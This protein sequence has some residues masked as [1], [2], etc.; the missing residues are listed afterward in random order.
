MTERTIQLAEEPMP[1]ITDGE[2][3]DIPES[4]VPPVQFS[5]PSANLNEARPVLGTATFRIPKAILDIYRKTGMTMNQPLEA[6][7]VRYEQD[8]PDATP[9]DFQM[10]FQDV[11]ELSLPFTEMHERL[12]R[13][14]AF[15]TNT[16]VIEDTKC[17]MR[18]LVPKGNDVVRL[19]QSN[20][21]TGQDIE[22]TFFNTGIVVNIRPPLD[23]EL[24]DLE[25]K[26]SVDRSNVGMATYGA[27]LTTDMGVHLGHLLDFALSLVTWTNL[28]HEGDMSAALRLHL[29]GRESI[30]VL[31]CGVLAS[32][33][34]TGFPWT[35]Q[36]H[37]GDCVAEEII[38]VFFARAQWTDMS[39]FTDEHRTVLHRNRKVLPEDTCIDYIAKLPNSTDVVE[40]NGTVFYLGLPSV[41]DYAYSTR[42]WLYTIEEENAA[43]LAKIDSPI[44]RQAFLDA[45]IGSRVLLEHSHYIRSIEV[46]NGKSTVTTVERADIEAILISGSMDLELVAKLTN[47]IANFE[48]SSRTTF[49]GHA[50]RPCPTCGK[51]IHNAEGP[52]SSIVPLPADRI[53]FTHTQLKIQILRGLR[54]RT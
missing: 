32:M 40:H 7:A 2:D 24:V 27:S 25:H 6:T 1:P 10:R 43:A 8:F 42:R 21:A 3:I 16:V 22:L 50:N 49:I 48:L 54:E 35:V 30:D 26:M 9:E 15:W 28:Q 51:A 18:A 38:D 45:R 37:A 46:N 11:M 44:Q 36:C 39:M 14:K 4:D 12:V 5:I 19:F 47:A 34:P 41:A 20:N 31:L 23:S 53:F 52:W 29:R 13:D 17:C 33:Y